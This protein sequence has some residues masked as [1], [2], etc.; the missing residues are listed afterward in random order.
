VVIALCGSAAYAQ[1]H[2]GVITPPKTKPDG[3]VITPPA[4]RTDPGIEKLPD[5]GTNQSQLPSD[6]TPP[7][8]ATKGPGMPVAPPD[9]SA[10]P[11]TGSGVT[12]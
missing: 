6:A 1:T 3:S 2:E 4:A 9:P 10:T 5:K 11:G 8:P 12:R 7:R